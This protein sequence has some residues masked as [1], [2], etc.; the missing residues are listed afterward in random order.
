[1]LEQEKSMLFKDSNW[2]CPFIAIPIKAKSKADYENILRV[3]KSIKINDQKIWVYN[4]HEDIYIIVIAGIG[5]AHLE[6]IVDTINQNPKIEFTAGKMQVVYKKTIKSAVKSEGRYIKQSG[7]MEHYAHCWIEIEPKERGSGYEFVNKISDYTIIPKKYIPLINRGI[8]V[9][10]ANGMSS[11]CPIVDIKVTLIDGSYRELDSSEM[12]FKMAGCI[13]FKEGMR[14]TENILLEPIMKVKL[15]IQANEDKQDI[16]NNLKKYNFILINNEN[17]VDEINGYIQLSKL[18]NNDTIFLDSSKFKFLSAEISHYE[19][20]IDNKVDY[21]DGEINF[22]ELFYNDL[23]QIKDEEEEILEEIR[24]CKFEIDNYNNY[25]LRENILSYES[26]LDRLGNAYT[27]LSKIRDAEENLVKSI[28]AYSKA[29]AKYKTLNDTWRY[30]L[31]QKEIAFCYKDLA[32]IRNTEENLFK[33]IT[34][35]NDLA[36]VCKSADLYREIGEIYIELSYIKNPE[37]NLIKAINIF[38]KIINKDNYKFCQSTATA[39]MLMSE[40]RNQK[41]YLVMA[42]N[43]LNKGLCKKEFGNEISMY[44]STKNYLGKTYFKL[45]KFVNFEENLKKSIECFNHALQVKNT[46]SGY[47]FREKYSYKEEH[48]VDYA[49]IQNNLGIAYWALSQVQSGEN[50][51]KNIENSIL[52]FKESIDGYMQALKTRD[53]YSYPLQYAEIQ[54]NLGMVY[55][56]LSKLNCTKDNIAKSEQAFKEALKV[57]DKERYPLFYTKTMEN[58]KK[59]ADSSKI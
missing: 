16:I 22:R 43:I 3:L 28:D 24:K 40:I 55:K 36:N 37:D 39:Y 23:S 26:F 27:R 54:N 10:M 14:N 8:M 35:F 30:G 25:H 45:S 29:L 56:N 4:H 34:A 19:N 41:E 58:L 12:D 21:K 6:N 5:I 18:I 47:F 32:K 59:E 31:I 48:S 7:A 9:V 13:A 51:N 17:L 2:G 50:M 1:M 33:G 46:E 15:A 44:V 49:K 42:L 52:A 20:V 38:D 53:F 11:G 57:Y